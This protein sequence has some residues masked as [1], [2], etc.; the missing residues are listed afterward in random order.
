MYDVHISP[1]VGGNTNLWPTDRILI[2]DR[3]RH[4]MT[5]FRRRLYHFIIGGSYTH[6][7]TFPHPKWHE[8]KDMNFMA[9]NKQREMRFINFF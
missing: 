7:H 4:R 8:T 2:E 9:M 6:V 1:S 3:I 5:T